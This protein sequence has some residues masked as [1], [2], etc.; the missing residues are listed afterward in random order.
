MIECQTFQCLDSIKTEHVQESYTRDSYPLLRTIG[1]HHQ[2]DY[3]VSA[4]QTSDV[5][6]KNGSHRFVY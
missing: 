4:L 3:K 1:P 5:L 2:Q 6:N